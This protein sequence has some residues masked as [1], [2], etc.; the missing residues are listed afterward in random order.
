MANQHRIYSDSLSEE[1]FR[2][3]LCWFEVYL[4]LTHSYFQFLSALFRCQVESCRASSPSSPSSSTS[5][6]HD[7]FQIS[8]L[9]DGIKEHGIRCVRRRAPNSPLFYC[10]LRLTVDYVNIHKSMFLNFIIRSG[11]L[12]AHDSCLFVC[13]IEN[14]E[15]TKQY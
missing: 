11:I 1:S 15:R 10:F 14:K 6:T 13:Q 2:C 3:P 5:N 4:K 8:F 9:F 12:F 7:E